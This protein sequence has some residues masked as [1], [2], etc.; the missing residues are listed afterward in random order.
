MWKKQDAC[1]FN[2][3]LNNMPLILIVVM[4]L[5][6]SLNLILKS[7]H[8]LIVLSFGPTG[9]LFHNSIKLSTSGFEIYVG[10]GIMPK[11]IVH[12]VLNTLFEVSS[13]QSS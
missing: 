4:Q 2:V 5:S 10:P 9:I 11:I 13:E 1:L 3:D 8:R 6:N 12:F 7:V